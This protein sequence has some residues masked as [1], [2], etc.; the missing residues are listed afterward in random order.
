MVKVLLLKALT[1]IYNKLKYT[2]MEFLIKHESHL[3]KYICNYTFAMI[4]L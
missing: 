1:S 3:F 4:K 2:V